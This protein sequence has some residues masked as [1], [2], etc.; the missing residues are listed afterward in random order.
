MILVFVSFE[1]KAHA[2]RVA[3][4]LIDNKIAACIQLLP[5]TSFYV[6][7]GEK[8]RYKEI[9]AIIKTTEEKFGDIEKSMK[10]LLPYE[11]PQIISIRAEKAN[12]SYLQWVKEAVE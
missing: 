11:I 5:V 2:E 3:K 9:E 8:V 12:K 1:E 6:W 4:Y 10:E 7:K